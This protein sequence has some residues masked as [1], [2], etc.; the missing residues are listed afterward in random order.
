VAKPATKNTKFARSRTVTTD[1][2]E[3]TVFGFVMKRKREKRGGGVGF[4]IS[5][6]GAYNI[7]VHPHIELHI[8]H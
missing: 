5:K 2:L 6:G 1:K 8:S 4:I 7:Q 3:G